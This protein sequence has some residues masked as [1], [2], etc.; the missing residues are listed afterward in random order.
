MRQ[1]DDQAKVTVGPGDLWSPSLSPG[2]PYHHAHRMA[3]G[4][5]V[6]SEKVEGDRSPSLSPLLS[7]VAAGW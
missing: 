4:L 7:S 2:A 6:Q 5:E 1:G 3:V